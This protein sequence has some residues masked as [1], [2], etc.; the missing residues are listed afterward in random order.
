MF[1]GVT[2]VHHKD[3]EDYRKSFARLT[4]CKTCLLQHEHLPSGLAEWSEPTGGMFLWLK[5]GVADTYDLI[6]VRARER[7]VLFV[8]GSAFMLDDGQPSQHVRAS[9]S[10]CTEEQMNLVLVTTLL[11]QT[12]CT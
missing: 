8:P 11:K 1:K 10:T 3:I 4:K 6:T 12:T 2:E 7:E 5:L 9:Y